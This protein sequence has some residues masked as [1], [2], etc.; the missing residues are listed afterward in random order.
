MKNIIWFILCFYIA[1]LFAAV[2]ITGGNW[3]LYALIVCG[4]AIVYNRRR[5]NRAV[6]IFRIGRALALYMRLHG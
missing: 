6:N 5:F 4:V 2:I 1:C 3:V